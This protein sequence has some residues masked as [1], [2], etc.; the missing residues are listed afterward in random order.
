MLIDALLGFLILLIIAVVLTVGMHLFVGV[1][2]VPT[3]MWV[4]RAMVAA[5]RLRDGEIVYDLGAGDGRIVMEAKRVCAGISAT[6]CELVPTIW[7]LG[8][9]RR[10]WKRSDINW[11]C[12]SVFS[13]DLRDADVIFLYM[14]PEFLKRLLPKFQRELQPGTRIISHTFALPGL[15][16]GQRIEYHEGRRSAVFHVYVWK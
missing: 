9:V 14:T 8:A 12:C 13:L 5:A 16:G 4:V 11:K 10:M 7:A 3:P 15:E 6:G 1:P 2:Y